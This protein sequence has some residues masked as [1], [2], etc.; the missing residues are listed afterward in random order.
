MSEF[1]VKTYKHLLS[2][3]A[4]QAILSGGASP[5]EVDGFLAD[6]QAETDAEV[7]RDKTR[8]HVLHLARKYGWGN[9]PLFRQVFNELSLGEPPAVERWEQVS[10]QVTGEVTVSVPRYAGDSDDVILTAAQA[11]VSDQRSTRVAR[12]VVSGA[13]LFRPEPTE[14]ASESTEQVTA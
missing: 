11:G 7:L 1:E 3:W 2:H 5:D 9:T 6:V 13:T 10:V 14:P 4:N 12:P 8:E